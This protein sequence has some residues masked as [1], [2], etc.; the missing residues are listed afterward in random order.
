MSTPTKESSSVSP[1]V[2]T[3]TQVLNEGISVNKSYHLLMKRNLLSGGASYQK[4]NCINSIKAV[5]EK[6]NPVPGDPFEVELIEEPGRRTFQSRRFLVR[7][8]RNGGT[9]V[10]TIAGG[11]GQVYTLAETVK[12]EQVSDQKGKNNNDKI[13]RGISIS[14]RKI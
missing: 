3:A 7:D 8:R 13:Y 9:P 1:T 12:D 4:S 10:A 5:D 2:S 14:V 11:V 6:G